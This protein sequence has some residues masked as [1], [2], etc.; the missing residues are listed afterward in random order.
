[1]K[2]PDFDTITRRRFLLGLL[3]GAASALTWG[4]IP[5][6]S[7]SAAGRPPNIVLVLA[8]DLGYGDLGCYGQKRFETPRADR[9]AKEGVRFTQ[10]YSGAPICAPSRTSLLT[11]R[12][13]GHIS[14]RTNDDPIFQETGP[15]CAG[16]LRERGYA[17]GVFGKWGL[18]DENGAGAPDLAGFDEFFGYLDH[19]AAHRQRPGSLWENRRRVKLPP[20]TYAHDRIVERALGF[21]REN[22]DRPFFL[23][24]APTLPHPD[25]DVP[26]EVLRL[27][28]GRY[29]EV[30]YVQTAG[31]EYLSQPTPR[32]AYA[33]MVHM[34][35]RDVGRLLDLLRELGLDE[36]TLVMLTS[37]NGAGRA[38]G[39][40]PL[41]FDSWGPFEGRKRTLYEGGI[42]VPLVARWPGMIPAGAVCA[43]TGGLW[44][45]LPTFAEVAGA[46]APPNGD[47][48]SLLPLLGGG[49]RPDPAFF[50]WEMHRPH[51]VQA[52]RLD[53]WKGIRDDRDGSFELYDLGKDVGEKNDVAR[54][55]PET[56]RRMTEIMRS[57][58]VPLSR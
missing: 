32:A 53:D 15:T 2:T 20:E 44:E 57:A 26:E 9:M 30:P 55:H 7:S 49:A 54:D 10:F 51:M 34:I 1:M 41:F 31:K 36:K 42:R 29:P 37:D 38:G 19:R 13:A 50:Y 8:D 45:M 47:G 28:R 35:D 22:R 5:G 17:T 25:L 40:D 24:L 39:S 18:G 6:R 4:C 3:G 14:I 16:V 33:A 48:A 23:L 58:H 46:P 52:V 43:R 27:F 11:G 12:H 56:V 21:V